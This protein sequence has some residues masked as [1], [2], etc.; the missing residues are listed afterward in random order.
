MILRFIPND[1]CY[2]AARIIMCLDIILWFLKSLYTYKFLRSVGP[3]LYMIKKMLFQLLYFLLIVVLFMFA[4]GISTHSM[5][6]HNQALDAKLLKNIFFPAYFIIGGEYYTMDL[7]MEPQ[8]TDC[9][10]STS[11]STTDVY[12]ENECPEEIGATFSLVLYVIYLIFLNI[13]LVN[14]LIAIFNNTYQLIESEA[15]KIW[16][17]DRYYLVFNFYSK[18][19]LP[20]P[21]TI[22]SY[23]VI[24]IRTLIHQCLKLSDSFNDDE[25]EHDS[26][27]VR[28]VKKIVNPNKNNHRFGK[29]L[30]F[31]L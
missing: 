28:L 8:D 6:F 10:R 15:N 30:F 9:Q 12:P 17:F 18:P 29:F 2:L 14:L 7:I 3:K 5:M 11:I 23:F 22:L 1:S 16:K 27:L 13:L 19:R 20:P 21:F 25:Y 24:L 26:R 31:I 4:F